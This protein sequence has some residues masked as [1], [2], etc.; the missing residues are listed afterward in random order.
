M[1]ELLYSLHNY[2]HIN[3]KYHTAAARLHIPV[4]IRRSAPNTTKSS[5]T[6]ELPC[7][8]HIYDAF[9]LLVMQGMDQPR[10]SAAGYITQAMLDQLKE[11]PA[12][13]AFAFLPFAN[14]PE[15]DAMQHHDAATDQMDLDVAVPALEKPV[16]SVA[17]D[18]SQQQTLQT[19]T[20]SN[21]VLTETH[22]MEGGQTATGRPRR[23]T[24]SGRASYKVG[25][26]P[27]RSSDSITLQPGCCAGT[28]ILRSCAVTAAPF[29]G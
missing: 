11:G 14:N 19:G 29:F 25:P 8:T 20:H 12:G 28:H 21:V 15:H 22:G 1:Q 4:K 18:P 24:K 13:A 9:I 17:G 23:N 16:M 26:V 10:S 5:H 7:T 3:I 27:W 2:T 6:T